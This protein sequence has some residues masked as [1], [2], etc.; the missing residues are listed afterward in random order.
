M[1]PYI[2]DHASEVERQ[3]NNKQHHKELSFHPTNNHSRLDD[4]PIKKFKIDK[5]LKKAG[6]SL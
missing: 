1:I 4:Q 2:K 3:I 5:L 6:E